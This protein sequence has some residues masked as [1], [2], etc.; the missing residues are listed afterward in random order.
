MYV[1][2]L[3]TEHDVEAGGCYQVING[4]IPGVVDVLDDAG[5][6]YTLTVGEYVESDEEAYLE[7]RSTLPRSTN[8][9]DILRE[10]IEALQEENAE[11][12]FRLD[13]L[14]K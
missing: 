13:S 7:Y 9:L 14:E 10:Q 12:K 3:V 8:E 11:L 6:D 2:S 5:D 1:I 4:R